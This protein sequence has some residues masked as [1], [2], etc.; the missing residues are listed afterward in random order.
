MQSYTEYFRQRLKEQNAR[1]HALESNPKYTM[2]N[3]TCK[4]RKYTEAMG[5]Q[6]DYEVVQVPESIVTNN[7]INWKDAYLENLFNKIININ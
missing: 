7:G 3:I 1:I 5:Y 6:N 4:K 2:P